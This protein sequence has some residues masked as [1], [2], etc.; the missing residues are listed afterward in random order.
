MNKENDFNNWLDEFIKRKGIKL[1]ESFT[2]EADK[3]GHLFDYENVI[4]QIKT[5]TDKEKN[6]IKTMLIKLD[7]ENRDIK[8]YLRH[9]AVSLAK[10]I[11]AK[12]LG[13]ESEDV[14]NQIDRMKAKEDLIK[15]DL[16]CKKILD[17]DFKNKKTNDIKDSIISRV[18][19]KAF[20]LIKEYQISSDEYLELLEQNKDYKRLE[21]RKRKMADDRYT[22]IW[23]N[24]SPKEIA[25]IL[26][27]N[28]EY[29]DQEIIDEFDD[30]ETREDIK[31]YLLELKEI[32]ESSKNVILDNGY[33][34]VFE[35]EFY[36]S[37][38]KE[39]CEYSQEFAGIR[40]GLEIATITNSDVS[41]EAFLVKYDNNI[42]IIYNFY[43]KASKEMETYEYEVF[44]IS[45]IMSKE[46]LI[47]KMKEKL[48]YFEEKYN[49]LEQDEENMEV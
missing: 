9:L 16:I 31:D 47:E 38:L 18:N 49:K 37:K 4:D 30:E 43:N 5:A 32:E 23:E 28:Y 40:E 1:S 24:C 36:F 21:E 46:E 8:A 6:G 7:Y 39:I 33:I 34:F 2:V 48:E 11:N 44:D 35:N 19:D 15:L 12:V 45:E 27:G 22:M 3:V 10:L 14:K 42:E 13:I 26:R 20:E 29:T 41:K 17:I 25:E